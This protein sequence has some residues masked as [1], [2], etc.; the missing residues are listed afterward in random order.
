MNDEF[1]AYLLSRQAPARK[2]TSCL[3]FVLSAVLWLLVIAMVILA[4]LTVGPDVL[5]SYKIVSPETMAR[6][7]NLGGG[8]KTTI[9][10]LGA[11]PAPTALQPPPAVNVWPPNGVIR[12]E[13]DAPTAEPPAPTATPAYLAQCITPPGERPCWLP[14]DQAWSPPADIPETPIVL[15]PPTDAPALVFSDSA[16]AAWRPPLKLPEGCKP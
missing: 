12:T 8:T 1:L 6:V 14:A 5:V 15:V 7:L 2:Q 13:R 3:G 16:C 4:L 10:P 9:A 11:T